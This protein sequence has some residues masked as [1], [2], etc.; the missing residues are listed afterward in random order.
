MPH[1]WSLKTSYNKNV[2]L[3]KIFIKLFD[4]P[5]LKTFILS[6]SLQPTDF[7]VLHFSQLIE[8]FK[9]RVGVANKT[10]P[11]TDTFFLK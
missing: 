8:T 1:K 10:L 5:A 9:M 7:N 2:G 4:I 11:P 3:I 6:F